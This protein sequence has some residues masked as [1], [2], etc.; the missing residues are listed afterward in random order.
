MGMRNPTLKTLQFTPKG[1]DLNLQGCKMSKCVKNYKNKNAT[2]GSKTL[3]IDF[4]L[5]FIYFNI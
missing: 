5:V 4:S 2:F 1:A 3:F